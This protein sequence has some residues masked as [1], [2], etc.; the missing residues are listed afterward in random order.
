MGRPT[1]SP[2]RQRPLSW[3]AGWDVE[4]SPNRTPTSVMRRHRREL[5]RARSST[6]P[7]RNTAAARST[8]P[9]TST[10]TWDSCGWR[11]IGLTSPP[12]LDADA[13]KRHG[14]IANTRRYRSSPR[15]AADPRS[16][17]NANWHGTATTDATPRTRRRRAMFLHWRRRGICRT[18]HG[19]RNGLGLGLRS[20]RGSDRL[21]ASCRP[22]RVGCHAGVDRH[23]SAIDRQSGSS[24]SMRQ[25]L[26]ALPDDR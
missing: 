8:W 11:T 25:P 20:S 14:G 22:T 7:Q 1:S 6:S 10:A 4:S 9:V 15:E 19:R 5:G 3:P 26:A 12:Q 23:A 21:G 2:R 18:V 24:L 16:L 17:D 13:I